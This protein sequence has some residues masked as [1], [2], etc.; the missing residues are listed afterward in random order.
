[1]I[2]IDLTRKAKVSI[3][4]TIMSEVGSQTCWGDTHFLTWAFGLYLSNGI[5]NHV[6][7]SNHIPS[8]MFTE[9]NRTASVTPA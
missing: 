4:V 3:V 6:Y 2:Q 7:P 5:I 9:P 1:M 8:K